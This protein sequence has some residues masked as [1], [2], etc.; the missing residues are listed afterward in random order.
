MQFT[1]N[2][3]S[4]C[5][6][7]ATCH[8]QCVPGENRQMVRGQQQAAWQHVEVTTN[9]SAPPTVKRIIN[10]CKQNSCFLPH[11]AIQLY[12]HHLKV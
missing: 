8:Q 9:H 5:F 6:I 4:E 2:D 1:T 3:V 11:T 10:C 12:C 7:V